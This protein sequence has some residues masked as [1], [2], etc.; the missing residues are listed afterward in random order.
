MILNMLVKTII[1]APVATAL[2]ILSQLIVPADLLDVIRPG[3][4]L[5]L[6]IHAVSLSQFVP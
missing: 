6:H 5:Q 3:Q 4:H 2:D 1:S